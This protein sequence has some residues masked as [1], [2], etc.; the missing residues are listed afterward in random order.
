[1]DVY[2][3]DVSRSQE[4][5]YILAVKIGL[6]LKSR[7][8]RDPTGRQACLCY[9]HLL[10]TRIGVVIVDIAQVVDVHG[11]SLL[12]ALPQQLLV[13]GVCG[14]MLDHGVDHHEHRVGA[15]HGEFLVDLATVPQSLILLRD[16][17]FLDMVHVH[18]CRLVAQS[19]GQC[20]PA[21]A[22]VTVVLGIR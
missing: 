6:Y 20:I 12:P 7:R 16:V 13:T 18:E 4:P 19:P 17:R 10:L 5:P 15:G 1:M 14:V 11:I 9:R 2:R 21:S 8:S 3:Y 22:D